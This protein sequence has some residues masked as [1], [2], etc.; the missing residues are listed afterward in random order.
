MR[1]V[2]A[3][4]FMLMLPLPASGV[5]ATTLLVEVRGHYGTQK[6]EIEKD[7]GG[8][9]CRTELTPYHFSPVQPY[10]DAILAKIRKSNQKAL[11]PEAGCRDIVTIEDRTTSSPKT[12]SGCAENH[13]FKAFLGDVNR[14]CGRN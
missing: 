9:R 5:A 6:T 14:Y 13:L 8:W 2:R 3:L 10:S 11:M 4:I 1:I 12:Y 7:A